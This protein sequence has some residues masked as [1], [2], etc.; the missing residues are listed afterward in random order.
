MKSAMQ[1]GYC[2]THRSLLEI[3]VEI[4]MGLIPRHSCRNFQFRKPHDKKLRPLGRGLVRFSLYVFLAAILAML[5]A[6]ISIVKA[7]PSVSM[8]AAL[9]STLESLNQYPLAVDAYS[10]EPFAGTLLVSA[11]S[12]INPAQSQLSFNEI[13]F[14][15]E[16]GQ[17][18]LHLEVRITAQAMGSFSINLVLSDSTAQLASSS[19]QGQIAD[20][21]PPTILSNSAIPKPGAG[22]PVMLH[23]QT[24]ENAACRYSKA[25]SA[26]DIMADLLWTPDGRI[27][28]MTISEL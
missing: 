10:T 17:M 5:L 7:S 1:V 6:Q 23:L 11:S 16:S 18:H 4:S 21:T 9:P 27:H 14:T 19:L 8:Q 2:K 28:N 26:F 24:N 22:N 13:N 25:D 15:N 12:N 3:S 20:T